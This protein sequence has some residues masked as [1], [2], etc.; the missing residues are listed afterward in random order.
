MS[1][2]SH[3]ALR[4]ATA[5]TSRPRGPARRRGPGAGRSRGGVVGGTEQPSGRR[6]HGRRRARF[7]RRRA[8]ACTG[9]R[10][11]CVEV[12]RA[13]SAVPRRWRRT[14]PSP[15]PRAC[16]P[17]PRP[18][19]ARRRRSRRPADQWSP[20]KEWRERSRQPGS[21]AAAAR[22]TSARSVG[23]RRR[24]GPGTC[25]VA[26]RTTAVA[27]H[28]AKANQPASDARLQRGLMEALLLQL[29][30]GRP[31][32]C[33]RPGRA[34][35]RAPGARAPSSPRRFDPRAARLRCAPC[36]RRWRA[37]TSPPGR[38]RCRAWG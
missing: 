25:E 5:G 38:P 10:W 4:P 27:P 26:A 14:R 30:P 2:G 13:P 16:G 17:R 8:G 37:C 12:G 1:R 15:A 6:R 33:H 9:W 18:S 36:W 29:S 7:S 31:L 21:S 20:G 19:S 24:S 35:R 34:A 28:S 32:R 11:P 22:P 23:D 3:S